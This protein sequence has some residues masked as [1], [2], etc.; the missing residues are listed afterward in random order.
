MSRSACSRCARPATHCLCPLIP[1]LASRTRVVVL[2]HPA[3]A[4]HPLNTAR[5]A[6]LGLSSARVL[7]GE[8]FEPA[9]WQVPG[10]APHLLFPGPEARSLAPG[11]RSASDLPLL[12]VVPDGTWRHARSLLHRNPEVAGLPRLALPTGTGARYRVRH[13]REE[14]ALSTL[15]AIVH[16]LNA[17]EAPACYDALLRPFDA[18][19]EGQIAGMGAEVYERHHV[20]RQGTR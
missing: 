1:A 15:E 13:A 19:V 5:L 10:H 17:L 9:Q 2:Q 6:A 12:L 7:V 18:L 4:R 11:G 14:G 16:A 8:R 3:E 20:R